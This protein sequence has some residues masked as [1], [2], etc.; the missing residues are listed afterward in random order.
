L[1]AVKWSGVLG[2]LLLMLAAL[3]WAIARVET[4]GGDYS[5]MFFVLAALALMFGAVALYLALEFV[6]KGSG[7]R[8]ATAC[9]LIAATALALFGLGAGLRG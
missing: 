9:A 6:R 1:R 8:S 3:I 5:A 7:A 2:S 4:S